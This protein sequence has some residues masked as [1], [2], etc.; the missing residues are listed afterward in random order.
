MHGQI[1]ILLANLTPFLRQRPIVIM[2]GIYSARD[3]VLRETNV[4]AGAC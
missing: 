3:A 2:R 1:C 4:S